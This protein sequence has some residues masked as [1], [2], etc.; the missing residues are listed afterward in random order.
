MY[1][2]FQ[3]LACLC[4]TEAYMVTVTQTNTNTRYV[5]VGSETVKSSGQDSIGPFGAIS[6]KSTMISPS[7]VPNFKSNSMFDI[8]YINMDSEKKRNEHLKELFSASRCKGHRFAAV[9]GKDMI[10][11]E[12]LFRNHLA[13]LKLDVKV[14]LTEYAKLSDNQLGMAGCKLSHYLNCKR[15]ENTNS[16]KPV[17]ILEDDVDLEWDFVE[18][19][20]NALLKMPKDWEVLLITGHYNPISPQPCAPGSPIVKVGYFF[21]LLGYIV[22]GS[23]AAKKLAN[24]IESK[25]A[26]Y[27]PVDLFFAHQS[28]NKNLAVYALK[29]KQ[30][31]QLRSR[32]PTSIPTSQDQIYS[33][34]LLNSLSNFV[35]RNRGLSN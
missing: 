35:G 6:S 11:N 3:I 10:R 8:C 14:N 16:S 15:I 13:S 17:L 32:F 34:P 21:E 25:C 30:A 20:E 12:T 7:K 4:F 27:V 28:M 24:L 18:K 26:P 2:A 33:A 22:N 29:Q 1:N 9:N 31:I 23:E 5:Y 19:I